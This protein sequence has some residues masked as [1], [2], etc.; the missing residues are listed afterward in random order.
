M[1]R[2]QHFL[3]LVLF[4]LLPASLLAG[5]VDETHRIK[6][7]SA[8]PIIDSTGVMV[9]F[10]KNQQGGLSKAW[11]DPSSGEYTV[12]ELLPSTNVS[13]PVTKM[14]RNGV[15]WAIWEKGTEDNN[16][17]AFSRL[18]S[19][20]GLSPRIVSSQKG[21]HF[22]P[23]FC[24]DSANTAWLTWV[25]YAEGRAQLLV[26]EMR[27]QSTWLVNSPFFDSVCQPKII[28]DVTG[29]IWI[30]WSGSVN[31]KDKILS[32]YWNGNLWS[33]PFEI[34]KSSDAPH[35]LPDVNL[36][37]NGFPWVT[38]CSHDGHDYEIFYSAW[39]GQ[40]WS[41]Q[42]SVTDNTDTD[43]HPSLSFTPGGIPVVVWSK[44]SGGQNSVSCRYKRKDSW[45]RE[46]ILYSGK[47]K[48]AGSPKIT[49]QGDKIGFLWQVGSLIHSRIIRLG[50][51][52]QKNDSRSDE[53]EVKTTQQTTLAENKYIGFGDSITY[54]TMDYEYTPE[55]G[56]IPRLESLLWTA[57]GA[58]YVINEGWPGELTHQ[59]LA[60]MPAVLE[61]HM[62]RYLL[63]MEGTND[64][65][66][67]QISMDTTAYNL[68]Q[69]LRICRKE[70]VFP[71]L[72]TIIPRKDYRW[73]NA[74]YKQRI[75][76]LND[77]IRDLAALLKVA[78]VD[79]FDIYYTWPQDDGGW[80]SLL[81]TDKVHPNQKGYQVMANAWLEEI[82]RIPF[83]AEGFTVVRLHDQVGDSVREAN[84]LMWRDS[85]KI[86]DKSDF[87]T[88]RIYRKKTGEDSLPFTVVK[89]LLLRTPEVYISGVISFPGS[90]NFKRR[91]LDVNIEYLLNYKYT[92][93]M[94]R[95]DGVE[96]PPSNIGQDTSQGGSEN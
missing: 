60:R 62:T 51:L 65:I 71:L 76:D 38:W 6:G 17:I 66:F 70:E 4:A 16:A 90:D 46:I 22:A 77:K 39:D 45:S 24:F 73:D 95:K 59:G 31:G 13:A 49:I 83:P 94:V 92:V 9:C 25:C 28:A 79:M 3:L 27:N 8:S 18:E 36:D 53:N 37:A 26:K 84:S 88:Y 35:I 1:K 61:K 20:S 72:S 40:A 54:G 23:D 78:S 85:Q 68:E 30:F 52:F 93:T 89:T 57:Y 86:Q 41:E 15:L 12:K 43:V 69:M 33:T 50:E 7:E 96:G 42:V 63:L 19:K 21:Y 64:V 2:T 29:K 80:R 44:S 10:F 55:L 34:N 32:S 56:Y 87:R 11:Q 81:S 91:Y 67:N 74:F 75:F 5:A 58:T 48:L 47:G 14:D 82:Q